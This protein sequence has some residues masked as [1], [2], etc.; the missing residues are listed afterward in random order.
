MLL[1]DQR[2]E[3]MDYVANLGKYEMNGENISKVLNAMKQDGIVN[4]APKEVAE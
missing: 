1:D 3:N 4:E 2:I